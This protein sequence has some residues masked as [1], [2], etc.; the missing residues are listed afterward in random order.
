MQ[1]IQ[2]VAMGKCKES[3]LRQ[4]CAEYQKRLQAYCNLDMIE[5]QPAPLPQ[6]PSEATVRQA[7]DKE[8]EQMLPHLRG[9]CVA[10]CVEGKP[11]SSEALAQ[12]IDNVA[13]YRDNG[14]MTF[15]IGSSYGLSNDV[16]RR[17]D[18]RL[19]MSTMTFPHQLARLM[20][21]EQIYRSYGILSGSAYHK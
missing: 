5:L 11:L 14:E 17:A 18:L 9:Y 2:I 10:L 16:K 20:L 7:L 8:A 13:R 4:G 15:C 1:H 19:S 3:Y 21:L 6:H 12:T